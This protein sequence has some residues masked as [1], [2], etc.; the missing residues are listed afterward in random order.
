MK[1][2]DFHGE[3]TLVLEN[4]HLSVEV[5][6]SAGPRIVRL[7]PSGS[8]ALVGARESSAHLGAG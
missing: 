3:E 1:R 8:S 6:A 7:T 2:G 5:L 4:E